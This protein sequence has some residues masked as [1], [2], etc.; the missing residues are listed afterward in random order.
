MSLTA[1]AL[2]VQN[3]LDA[4]RRADWLAPLLLRIYLAPVMWMA[5]WNKAMSFA[6]TVDW[7]GNADWGL[8]LPFPTLLASLAI[9]AELGGALSLLLG[10]GL[11]YMALP[12]MATMVVAIATVHWENGWLAISEGMGL[13]ATERTMEATAAL[14]KAKEILMEAGEYEALTR[15]GSLVVLNNGVEFAVTYLVM[16]LSLFFTGAGRWVSLDYWRRRRLD[17]SAAARPA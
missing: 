7:F 11:R 3:L 13:F 4:S 9:A 15:H 6:D 8:G 5:G 17:A 1:I 12:M 16:L 2:R 10:L 14:A